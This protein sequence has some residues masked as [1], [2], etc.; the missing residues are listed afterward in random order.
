MPDLRAINPMQ[1]ITSHTI[2]MVLPTSSV[3]PIDTYYSG[4]KII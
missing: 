2:I 1:N 4:V 3:F